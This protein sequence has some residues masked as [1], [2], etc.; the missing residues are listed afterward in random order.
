MG[1]TGRMKTAVSVP[2]ELFARAEALSAEL[3][4]SRSE[5][6]AR[7]LREFVERF[8]TRQLT[9]QMNEVCDRLGDDNTL[10]EGVKAAR[11]KVLSREAW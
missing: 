2:D 8:S 5:L 1:Y 11:R 9:Q 10:D 4:V 7:A 6:F 3:N